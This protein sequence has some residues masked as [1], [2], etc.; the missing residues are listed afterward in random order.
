MVWQRLIN[1]AE[2]FVACQAMQPLAAGCA[3]PILLLDQHS[4]VLHQ[5]ALLGVG[6]QPSLNRP[7]S[8]APPQQSSLGNTRPSQRSISTWATTSSQSLGGWRRPW[9][10]QRRQPRGG[11]SCQ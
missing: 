1:L 10:S 6:Q 9:G 3:F 4:A 5:Q 7:A 11:I 2:V 8:T